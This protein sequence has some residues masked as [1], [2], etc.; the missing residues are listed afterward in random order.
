MYT[1]ICNYMYIII[2]ADRKPCSRKQSFSKTCL[3]YH[4]EVTICVI[5]KVTNLDVQIWVFFGEMLFLPQ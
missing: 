2:P 1:D 4:S 3:S 5:E